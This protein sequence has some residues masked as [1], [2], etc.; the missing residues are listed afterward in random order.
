MGRGEHY[1]QSLESVV[2]QALG[3]DGEFWLEMN[4]SLHRAR[5]QNPLKSVLDFGISLAEV[6]FGISFSRGRGR[7]VQDSLSF[8]YMNVSLASAM[9]KA[10]SNWP[11]CKWLLTFW[12][13]KSKA[14]GF[15]TSHITPLC[16]AGNR[17]WHA[18][19]ILGLRFGK[20]SWTFDL[21]ISFCLW[22]DFLY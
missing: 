19:T 22:Y 9:M 12:P 1:F 7:T 18:L 6:R 5:L 20:L 11:S 2:F 10:T 13:G 17:Y 4:M 3:K 14:V 8:R 15:D 21:L 16:V